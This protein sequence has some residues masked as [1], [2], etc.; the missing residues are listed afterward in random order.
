MNLREYVS[1]SQAVNEQIPEQDRGKLG[2]TKL[3][4]VRFNTSNDC[5]LVPI[6]V[7]KSSMLTKRQALSQL[8][9]VYDPI[10]IVAPTLVKL[11]ELLREIFALKLEWKESVP[12]PICNRWR[13]A[14]EE[15]A[16]VEV[17]CPRY[18]LT[19]ETN[20]Y[21]LWAFADASKTTIAVCAYFR[22]N[23]TEKVSK[24]ISGKT[25]LAP[26]NKN[27]SIPRLELIAILLAMR[28]ARTIVNVLQKQEMQINIYSRSIVDKIHTEITDIRQ[29]SD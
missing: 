8:H 1:N 27:M 3:L 10:G 12:L 18:S 20:N 26:K 14:W 6:N 25:K 28:L 7:V 29:Q 16:G 21:S 4:G 2:I 9:S 11:K 17:Q 19:D 13:A 15:I 22:N 5:F 24:L 23:K